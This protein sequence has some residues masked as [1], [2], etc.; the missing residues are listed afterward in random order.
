MHLKDYLEYKNYRGNVFYSAEDRIFYGEIM[1]I[2]DHVSFEGDTVD[3]LE[4]DFKKAVDH[5]LFVCK[6][7]GKDPDKE[8]KGVFNIRI[9]PELHREAYYYANESGVTLNKLIGD[10]IENYLQIKH[11]ENEKYEGYQAINGIEGIKGIKDYDNI[12]YHNFNV[13]V[14]VDEM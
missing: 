4:E 9:S 13:K 12:I 14:D 2:K 11:Q 5:Y 8:F 10:C 1:G 3:S 7:I 6:K